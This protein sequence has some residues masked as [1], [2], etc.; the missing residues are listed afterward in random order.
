MAHRYFT[1]KP[2]FETD[3]VPV[4]VVITLCPAKQLAGGNCPGIEIK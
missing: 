3:Y 2:V 1:V 4:R